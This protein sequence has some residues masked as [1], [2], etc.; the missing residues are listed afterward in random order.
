MIGNAKVDPG[1]VFSAAWKNESEFAT[2]GAKHMKI[3]SM[4]GSNVNG[5]KGS[6]LK[7]LGNIAMTSVQYVLNGVL[8]TGC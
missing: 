2:C 1:Q 7:A 5:K 6:Y 8:L 4:Q 3:F